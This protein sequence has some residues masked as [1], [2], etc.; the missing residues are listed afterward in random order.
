M[1]ARNDDIYLLCQLLMSLRHSDHKL[2][3]CLDNI[4]KN[5]IVCEGYPE[6]HAILFLQQSL[7][8]QER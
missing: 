5:Y 7:Q 3:T 8:E 6:L 1:K 4:V 2:K